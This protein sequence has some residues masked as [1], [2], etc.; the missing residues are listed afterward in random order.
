MEVDKFIEEENKLIQQQLRETCERF[1]LDPELIAP[2]DNEGVPRPLGIWEK[3]YKSYAV[4]FRTLGAKRYCYET[5]DGKLHTV[6]SGVGKKGAEAL[7]GDIEKFTNDLVFGYDTA[8]KLTSCYNK[9][10]QTRACIVDYTGRMYINTQRHGVTLQP[11]TYSMSTTEA[12]AAYIE[13]LQQGFKEG[14][15]LN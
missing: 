7:Q 15:W 6:V 8:G 11:T 4:K 14:W 5:R 3:E 12:Y 2:L 9:E 10:D 1:D 13:E